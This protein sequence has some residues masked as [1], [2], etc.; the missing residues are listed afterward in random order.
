[1]NI[2][3]S[4]SKVAFTLFEL[5]VAACI[6]LLLIGT[7]VSYA[8]FT[9]KKAREA[10]LTN[11]LIN[12]RMS[13]EHYRIINGKFPQDLSELINQGLT[14]RSP[15]NKIAGKLFLSHFRV[16]REGCLLDP[17][18]NRYL[19]NR[20]NGSVYSGTRGYERR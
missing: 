8:G 2:F 7:F 5:L 20:E 3:L 15:G 6:I 16:D 9:L 1:M 10:A 18:M 12:I 11:E 4:R 14:S 17:F 19:Y 13:I